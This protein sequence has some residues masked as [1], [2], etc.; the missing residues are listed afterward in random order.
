MLTCITVESFFTTDPDKSRIEIVK[1]LVSNGADVNASGGSGMTPLHW[2]AYNGFTEISNILIEKK[3]SIEK[4]DK[5]NMT[6]LY[7]SA[8]EGHK[9]MIKLLLDKGA[10]ADVRVIQAGWLASA[11][12]ISPFA[13]GSRHPPSPR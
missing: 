2:A 12:V 6:P 9:A 5:D 11:T 3:A 4:K 7:L 1:M 10:K 8:R 13:S